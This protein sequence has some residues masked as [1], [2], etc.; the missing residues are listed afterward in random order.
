MA[1][2]KEH[3]ASL[4]FNTLEDF[5]HKVQEGSNYYHS[6]NLLQEQVPQSGGQK[7]LF[8]PLKITAALYTTNHKGHTQRHKQ[9]QTQS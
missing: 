6:E 3:N 7:H 1:R 9:T 4:P 2:G 8:I 5:V